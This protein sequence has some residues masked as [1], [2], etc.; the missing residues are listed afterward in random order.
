LKVL[1]KEKKDGVSFSAIFFSWLTRGGG[2][3][4][5]EG[6]GYSMKNKKKKSGGLGMCLSSMRSEEGLETAGSC[7]GHETTR[8]ASNSSLPSDTKRGR[9]ELPKGIREK[10][11]KERVGE[12]KGSLKSFFY[13]LFKNT[14]TVRLK[15]EA[16]S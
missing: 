10:K 12:E 15:E 4:E 16:T 5:T 13:S 2:E 8:P 14:P 11:E 7:G 1:R 6:G 9:S 3:K